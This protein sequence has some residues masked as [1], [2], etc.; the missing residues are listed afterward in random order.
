MS[1]CFF[2]GHRDTPDSLFKPLSDAVE[3]HIVEYGVTE[4]VVGGYGRFDPLAAKAVSEAKKRH[5]EVTLTLLL[6]YHPQERP[7]PLP[8]GFDGTFYPP[9]M[10]TVPRRAAIVRA[11]RYMADHCSFLIAYAEHSASNAAA[12][13]AHAQ[14]RAQK[15]L[16]RL[17]KLE[18]EPEIPCTVKG[19]TL[20]KNDGSIP[21]TLRSNLY[22]SE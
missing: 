13:V 2:I 16:M 17:T 15:G 11:N 18:P 9:G 5:P 10:E 7:V 20:S 6:P 3:R 4:F 8:P 1:L 12:L 19:Q 14:I 21:D 22:K